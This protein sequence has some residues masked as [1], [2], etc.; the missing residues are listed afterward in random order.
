MIHTSFLRVEAFSRPKKADYNK[1]NKVETAKSVKSANIF[2]KNDKGS[3][4]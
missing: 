1:E 2:L 4:M 3:E